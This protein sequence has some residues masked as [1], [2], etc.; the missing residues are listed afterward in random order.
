MTAKIIPIYDSVMEAGD[1]AVIN[2]ARE[3][4][5]LR[6]DTYA[7]LVAAT[8]AIDGKLAALEHRL[9]MKIAELVAELNEEE[10]VSHN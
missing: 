10:G 1:Q 5:A 4:I 9:D 2:Q 6:E 3:F 8:V 7:A